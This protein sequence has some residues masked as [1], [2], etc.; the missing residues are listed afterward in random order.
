MCWRAY[1]L[2]SQEARSGRGVF[3]RQFLPVGGYLSCTDGQEGGVYF[4]FAEQEKA[5]EEKGH[6]ASLEQSRAG[7]KCQGLVQT[8]V[9]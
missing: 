7:S 6:V 4:H 8:L 1:A 2:C 5:E 9:F 3:T